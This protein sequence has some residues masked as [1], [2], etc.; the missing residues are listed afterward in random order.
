MLVG[1]GLEPTFSLP[2]AKAAFLRGKKKCLQ[3]VFQSSLC[4]LGFHADHRVLMTAA[5]ALMLAAPNA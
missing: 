2:L 1:H 3:D 5:L 4:M